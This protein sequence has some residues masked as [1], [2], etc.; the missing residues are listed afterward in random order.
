MPAESKAQQ[1]FFGWIGSTPASKL[2]TSARKTKQGMTR[3]PTHNFAATRSGNLPGHAG[4]W[5]A[6]LPRAA[7]GR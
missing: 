4:R 6:G 2:L 3:Q 5:R 7:A 1:R